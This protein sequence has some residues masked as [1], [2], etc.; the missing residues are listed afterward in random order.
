LFT[1]QLSAHVE[2]ISTLAKNLPFPSVINVLYTKLLNQL[3]SQNLLGT[4]S[5]QLK[6][7]VAI[8]RTVPPTVSYDAMASVMLTMLLTP[9]E[10]RYDECSL[11]GNRYHQIQK[12]RRFLRVLAAQLGSMFDGKLLIQALLSFHVKGASWSWEDEEDRARLMFQCVTLSVAPWRNDSFQSDSSVQAMN[13]ILKVVRMLMLTYCCTEYGPMFR[14]KGPLKRID[15]FQGGFG[16]LK[17]G[18]NLPSWLTTIRC[19][20]FVEGSDSL[21]MKN[22]FTRGNRTGDE[23]SDW[24]E[25]FPLIR[26]CCQLAGD[27]QN[28]HIW[29][30]LKSASSVSG[31][32][33]EMAIQILE[34]I[35]EKCSE[36]QPTQMIV[37]D[38][39][40]IWELYNLVAYD[41][42]ELDSRHSG[43]QK[44]EKQ[45]PIELPRY[46]FPHFIRR[47]KFLHH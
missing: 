10:I 28:E 39:Q 36:S 47:Y 45:T 2:N 35:L 14:S 20:L 30:I 26:A 24:D 13:E 15:Y 9:S 8:H 21:Q 27:L 4:S 12:L 6:M 29:V 41:P 25:E 16:N 3:M 17:A 34:S 42:P 1:I 44:G 23:S 31:I 22:F 38:P 37:D 46:D 7:I 32:D 40:V 33:A 43:A 19:L 11:N 5:D 18:K